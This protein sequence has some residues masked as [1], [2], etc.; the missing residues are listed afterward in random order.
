LW[1]TSGCEAKYFVA[2]SRLDQARESPL[3]VSVL[4]RRAKWFT[5]HVPRKR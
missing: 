2:S 4:V 5:D 1:A 3:I